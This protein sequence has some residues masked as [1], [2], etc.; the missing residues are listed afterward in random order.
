[1]TTNAKLRKLLASVLRHR[2][3]DL[4][5]ANETAER[6]GDLDVD[7]VGRV[8]VAEHSGTLRFRSL[9]EQVRDRA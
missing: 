2:H 9:A 8:H 3:C 7:Q 5:A 1:M 4:R 6:L